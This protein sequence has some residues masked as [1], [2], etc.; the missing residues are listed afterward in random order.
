NEPRIEQVDALSLA[1]FK[2]LLAYPRWQ[3]LL[4]LHRA[5]CLAES[6]GTHTADAAEKRAAVIPP[7][8]I[9]PAP[10]VTGED[11]IARGLRP[12]PR[13]KVIL[14]T[15]YDA[16]LNQEITERDAA[17]RELERLLVT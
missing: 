16:Q 12:G 2:R 1:E 10:L 13:F 14:D 15:L 5:R 6:R 7:N 3:D 9:A 17:L 11:L 8:E 4:T